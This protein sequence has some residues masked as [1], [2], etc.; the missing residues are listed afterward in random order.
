MPR[1]DPELRKIMQMADEKHA[2]TPTESF[3]DYRWKRLQEL[4]SF[5]VARRKVMP[6]QRISAALYAA[7]RLDDRHPFDDND[8]DDIEHSS[9][10]TAYCDVFL[11][12]RKFASI[13]CLPTVQKVIPRGCTVISDIDQA[14]SVLL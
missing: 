8:P 9:V 12:E 5:V 2:R 1:L 11:T 14:I 7:M 3:D 6:S 10:A 13:L 4:E